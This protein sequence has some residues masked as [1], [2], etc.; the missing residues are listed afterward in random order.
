MKTSLAIA[1]PLGLLAATV[2][3]GSSVLQQR[4][5]RQAP[6]DE[7]LSWRLLVDL[8][9]RPAWLAGMGGNILAFLLQAVALGFAGSSDLPG[10][11]API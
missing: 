4:T 7:S 5:A 8:V 2:F 3:A 10:V 1:I 9:R 6:E 11:L